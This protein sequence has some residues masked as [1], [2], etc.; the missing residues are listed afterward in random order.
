MEEDA[1]VFL[2]VVAADHA[3]EGVARDGFLENYLATLPQAGCFKARIEPH[4]NIFLSF[5]VLAFLYDGSS[6]ELQ[7]L[8]EK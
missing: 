5:P 6:I 8:A 4:G 2:I 3:H 1:P 7:Y